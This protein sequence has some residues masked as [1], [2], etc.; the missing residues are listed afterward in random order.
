MRVICRN[1]RPASRNSRCDWRVTFRL[2]VDTFSSLTSLVNDEQRRRGA[3]KTLCDEDSYM[4]EK[5]ILA[6]QILSEDTNYNLECILRM[7]GRKM[8]A[9]KCSFKVKEPQQVW[10]TS[11][12]TSS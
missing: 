4:S 2:T 5:A 11:L 8:A 1:S 7:C 6:V 10:E 9:I 3:Y 12:S